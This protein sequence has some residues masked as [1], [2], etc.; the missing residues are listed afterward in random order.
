MELSFEDFNDVTVI[1][2]S[3]SLDTN[4]SP[5][6]EKEINKII[7]QGKNK[8]VIDLASTD[9]VSSA[10]LRIFLGTAKK[11]MTTG[12]AVKL[13]SPNSVVKEILEMSGFTTI[14]DVRESKSDAI[15]GL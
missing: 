15:A 5:E 9:Y 10:G 4:T 8:I 12:G 1:S 14:L 11:L 7:N 6:A 3:G 2:V 13:S